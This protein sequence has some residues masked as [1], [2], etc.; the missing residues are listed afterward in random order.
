M[1]Q[2]TTK[3][4]TKFAVM[5]V[6]EKEEG[7]ISSHHIGPALVEAIVIVLF[8]LFV[9][10]LCKI[11]YDSVVISNL[12]ADLLEEMKQV[13]ELT[14]QNE[15]LSIEN[16]TLNSKVTVLSETVTT[17]AANEDALSQEE[18][19]N[20]L[21]KGFPLSGS[22]TMESQGDY[23]EDADAN[24]ILKFKASAGV[25]VVSSGTGTVLSVEDDAEYGN[26]IIIDH[27]N[28]YRSIYRNGGKVLV[29]EGEVLGKGYILF[30]IGKDNTDL[31]YQITQDEEYIDPMTIINID[32]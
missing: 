25:N 9:F 10:F 11:I 12:R 3:K 17:K 7:V 2:E 32:G 23:T 31:G 18:V 13:N 14:D 22:A 19:E 29:K 15:S 20:A 4:R 1:A 27:G 16:E 21:P 5:L 28:G 30:S 26:R 6:R 24:P 8:A